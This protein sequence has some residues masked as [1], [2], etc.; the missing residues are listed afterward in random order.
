VDDLVVD[1]LLDLGFNALYRGDFHE[2]R[3]RADAVIGV[4]GGN[5]HAYGLHALVSLFEKDHTRAL[6]GA[7][8][9]VAAAGDNKVAL[10]WALGVLSNARIEAGDVRAAAESTRW[11]VELS[12]ELGIGMYLADSLKGPAAEIAGRVDELEVAGLLLGGAA[13]LQTRAGMVTPP[14]F[15]ANPFEDELRGRLGPDRYD[16]VVA[17]GAALDQDSLVALTVHLLDSVITG[18]RSV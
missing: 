13:G 2:A 11:Q 4:T 12:T 14:A 8:K 10:A 18:E 9:A 15:L 3:H 16:A 17:R 1:D 6:D 7:D 5:A